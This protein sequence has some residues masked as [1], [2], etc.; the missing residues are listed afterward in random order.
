M[1]NVPKLYP[2]LLLPVLRRGVDV[3]IFCAYCLITETNQPGAH[4]MTEPSRKHFF[5]DE[6]DNRTVVITY[7]AAHRRIWRLSRETKTR[8][9]Y[10]GFGHSRLA[11]IADLQQWIEDNEEA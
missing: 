4:H 2:G 10:R 5:R 6:Q 3:R 9:A 11:A 1:R 7:P 8:A